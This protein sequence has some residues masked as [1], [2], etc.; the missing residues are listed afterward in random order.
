MN[1]YTDDKGR[2]AFAV[3]GNDELRVQ[4]IGHKVV[5]AWLRHE[6]G[7]RTVLNMGSAR[8]YAEARSAAEAAFRAINPAPALESLGPRLEGR[9]PRTRSECLGE[10]RPC[11]YSQCM[12]HSDRG[13]VLDIA[14]SRTRVC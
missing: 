8:S 2:A 1:W 3:R 6:G 9:G 11:L 13:C 5:W 12:Y 10:K 7:Q 14:D 4:R